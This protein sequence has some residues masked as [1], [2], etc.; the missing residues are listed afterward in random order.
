LWKALRNLFE[1]DRSAARGTM[2]A[3]GLYIFKYESKLGNAQAQRLFESIK[4]E[5]KPD[6]E[7]PRAFPD[8]TVVPPGLIA[9]PEGI[10]LIDGLA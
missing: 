3:R 9:L 7:S 4:I 1:L 8:Y 5:K 2:A 10:T 6:V